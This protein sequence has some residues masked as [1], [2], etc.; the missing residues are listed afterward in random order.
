MIII[1]ISSSTTTT[2]TTANI[3]IIRLPTLDHVKDL[4]QQLRDLRLLLTSITITIYNYYY[5]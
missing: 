2:T 4:A 3:S 5:N 1:I